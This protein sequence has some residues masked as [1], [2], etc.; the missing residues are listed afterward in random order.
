MGRP[1]IRVLS[2]RILFPAVLYGCVTV[3]I[4]APP[5]FDTHNPPRIG[6]KYYP[7]ESKR[8]HEEGMC[9]VKVNIAADGTIRDI[10]LTLSTGYVRLDDACL[11]AFAHGG[12]IPAVVDGKPI[13]SWLEIPIT[14]KITR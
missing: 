5:Q 11:Q 6:T 4:A 3:A 14:W 2:L 1:D 7:A 12:L 13:D 9:K 10:K 8:L